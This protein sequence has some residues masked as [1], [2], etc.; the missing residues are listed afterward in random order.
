MTANQIA[1]WNLS[2]TNRHNI[3]T[4]G[5]T[6]RHN[7]QQESIDLSKLEETKRSNVANEKETNR[8]NLAREAE[9]HRSNTVRESIDLGQFNENIR[10]NKASERTNQQ[11]ADTNVKLADET[12]RSNK[13]RETE[14]KRSNLVNE[15][16]RARSNKASEE[17]AM[18]AAQ[19]R[20]EQAKAAQKSAEAAA[21]QAE[22]SSY[23]AS[24]TAETNRVR[25]AIESRLADVQ[26]GRL[27]LDAANSQIA[28][29]IAQNRAVWDNLL[30]STKVG[31]TEQ[32]KQKVAYEIDNVVADTQLKQ[33]QKDT[34]YARGIL[35]GVDSLL[36]LI[37][38]FK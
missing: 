29:E 4:E 5:E 15:A 21:K 37:R 27:S 16:E 26:A 8:S 38:T 36:N 14:T 9:T 19:A 20:I 28:N 32:Q 17:A 12:I 1:Y 22:T 23:L 34:G 33:S 24:V 3:A 35:M 13:E 7:R 25:N 6:G 30:T 11:N 18:I 31:L 10:H 2:E